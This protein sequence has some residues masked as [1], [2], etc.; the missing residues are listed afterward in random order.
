M[1]LLIELFILTLVSHSASKCTEVIVFKHSCT[2]YHF[3]KRGCNSLSA[4]SLKKCDKHIIRSYTQCRTYICEEEEEAA[5]D[6]KS[7]SSTRNVTSYHSANL[8]L[9]NDSSG[10]ADTKATETST[11]PTLKIIKFRPDLP[12]NFESRNTKVPQQS[13]SGSTQ[14]TWWS[15]LSKGSEL[16]PQQ[17]VGPAGT[18]H[19][20]GFEPH[21]LVSIQVKKS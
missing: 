5:E 20:Q 12:V 6:R 3:Q 14:E 21:K 11:L 17:Q 13:S 1:K 16:T 7:L 2:I 8:S 10:N 4:S 18:S 19:T 9:P 15:E